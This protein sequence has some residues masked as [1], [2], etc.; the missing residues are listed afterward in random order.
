M[1]VEVK[2]KLNEKWYVDR[3]IER[4]ERILKYPPAECKGKKL[5]GALAGGI[6]ESDVKNYAHSVGFFVLEL[7]GESV[8]LAEAPAG[9]TARQW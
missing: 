8:Q 9:F 4:M 2:R 5:I 7:S 6:V 3:H 1:A